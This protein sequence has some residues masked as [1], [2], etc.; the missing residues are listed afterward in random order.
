MRFSIGLILNWPRIN[1]PIIEESK[2]SIIGVGKREQI[3]STLPFFSMCLQ[4]VMPILGSLCIKFIRSFMVPVLIKVS[5][6][7]IS[8]Y[9]PLAC[10][11]P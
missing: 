9:F 11:M 8:R 2:K 4:L 7:K 10:L 6:F 1:L 3:V 5:E